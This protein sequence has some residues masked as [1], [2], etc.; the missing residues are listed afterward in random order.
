MRPNAV[1]LVLAIVLLVFALA[2]LLVGSAPLL[3]LLQEPTQR[4]LGWVILSELRLPRMLL[5]VLVG[6][7]L[8][9]SGAALQGLMRNPLADAGVMG[10]TSWGALGA[11]LCLYSGLAAS[12]ALALPLGGLVG[13]GIGVVLLYALA[14][15]DS[16]MGTLILAGI[17]L[18]SLAGAL[19]ALVLNFAPN[20]Y[21]AMEIIYWLLGSL[22]GP[23][24]TDVALAAPFIL[25]G[26]GMLL[27]SARGL[28]AL[29][30]G[31]DAA[32]S[33]GV[34]LGR[35]RALVILGT[36]LAVGAATAVSG[37]I[38]FV[39]L[40][41]P[42]ILRPH[43]AHRPGPLVLASTLG[44]AVLVL[45]AD[46]LVRLLPTDMELKLGVVTALVGAPFFLHLLLRERRR[47]LT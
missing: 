46:I 27:A 28:E 33:L 39:G 8:G 43:F 17:A 41:V 22:S 34:S 18:A 12:F 29:T 6:G 4:H 10:I 5:G 7:A 32:A 44:G 42:H 30:L 40:V 35:L 37:S 14:G 16:H 24:L 31:E 26:L 21:A 45:A 19:T 38:A 3:H 1:L 25:V 13:A 20:P 23:T 47:R 2:S 15:R 9:A 11:V 36:A